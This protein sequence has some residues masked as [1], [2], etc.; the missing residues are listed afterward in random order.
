MAGD[1][2]RIEGIAFKDT[3]GQ[4]LR[5]VEVCAARAGRP[6]PVGVLAGL[7]GHAF[8]STYAAGGKELW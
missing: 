2:V 7:F 8:D 6:W 5:C 1:V 4:V 3:L